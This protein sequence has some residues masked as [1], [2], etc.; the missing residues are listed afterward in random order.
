MADITPSSLANDLIGLK[1]IYRYRDMR[2]DLWHNMWL[3]RDLNQFYKHVGFRRYITN[4]P[5]A[6]VDKSVSILT[7]YNWRFWVNMVNLPEQLDNPQERE[8]I[9]QVE[10]SMLGLF[11]Y[12]DR[13]LLSQGYS[14]ASRV[15]AWYALVR[16]WIC[17][18]TLLDT[19]DSPIDHKFLDPRDT[20]PVW[21]GKR[22][23]RLY[24]VVVQPASWIKT[25][26]PDAPI[27]ASE[28]TSPYTP[29][30]TIIEYLDRE[31]YGIAMTQGVQTY[32]LAN[33]L[34]E[35]IEHGV[36]NL[37]GD[38]IVP[39]IIQPVNGSPSRRMPDNILEGPGPWQQGS[40]TQVRNIIKSK[41]WHTTDGW[42]AE[43][44]RSIYA[45][46]E[47]VW[48][49]FNEMLALTLQV[50]SNEGLGTVFA[51]SRSGNWAPPIGEFGR[52][53]V[54]SGRLDDRISQVQQRT[55][56]F[57]AR[58]IVAQT[59]QEMFWG[60]V[61]P[62]L[63]ADQAGAAPA[64]GFQFD[65]EMSAALASLLAFRE[66]LE[67]W[68][69][70]EAELLR[71]QF[72]S[73]RGKGLS[74]FASTIRS[75]RDKFISVAV[76]PKELAAM[77]DYTI[78]VELK[79][80]LP[81]DML[82]RV[83]IARQLLDPRRP[84]A[85]L[86]TVFDLVLGWDDPDGELDRIFEDMSM[87]EPVIVLERIAQAMERRGLGELAQ[88]IRAKEFKQKFIEDAQFK[89]LQ[90]QL[91]GRSP[92]MGAEAGPGQPPSEV[93]PPE[94]RGQGREQQAQPPSPGQGA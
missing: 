45:N 2:M 9:S 59:Q 78:D 48:P 70:A 71:D 36:K 55:T 19:D 5:A 1:A 85:S 26:W 90:A 68:G 86:R 58:T 69:R 54:I 61:P 47:D 4:F 20:Y 41:P 22:L 43:Q 6:L 74:P 88:D 25:H 93:Q 65:R 62:I 16:G 92:E 94:A 51:Q 42:T 35:P 14:K 38:P 23:D 17:S 40:S 91:G 50:V 64:S 84:I 27:P 56:P 79:P 81:E 8:R 44:G 32:G 67:T 60:T 29:Y 72:R 18:Y 30:Y 80:G 53:T 39:A 24:H 13:E 57:D 34:S 82:T 21:S 33:W 46:V 15:A 31:I 76:Q 10:R 83:T 52:G 28:L 3:L 75:N 77:P 73:G 87:T 37:N 89:M 11:S 12:I 63:M 49:L 7:R 66:G